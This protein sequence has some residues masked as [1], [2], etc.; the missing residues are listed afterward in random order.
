MDNGVKHA[1]LNML[2]YSF[3]TLISLISYQVFVYFQL[4]KFHSPEVSNQRLRFEFLTS[5]SLSI[6]GDSG[7]SP[8]SYCPSWRSGS[9]GLQAGGHLPG[10]AVLVF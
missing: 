9:A 6:L 3:I 7:R 1:L 4:T 8:E 5:F 10:Q 2:C